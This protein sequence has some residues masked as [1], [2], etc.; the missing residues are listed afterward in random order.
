MLNTSFFLY[1]FIAGALY[2]VPQGFRADAFRIISSQ[3]FV[4]PVN[5]QLMA[6]ASAGQEADIF[7]RKCNIV[8][9]SSI[10]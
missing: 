2:S 3:S 5:F 10:F 1:D 8:L 6:N 7:A 9:S 4:V